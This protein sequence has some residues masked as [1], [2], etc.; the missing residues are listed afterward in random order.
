MSTDR[1]SAIAALREFL[2]AMRDWE[3]RYYRLY[4]AAL[5]DEGEAKRLGVEMCNAKR[6][7]IAQWCS[8]DVLARASFSPSV[9]DPPVFDPDRD[10]LIVQEAS[11]N[12]V[13]VEHTQRVGLESV[14]RFC[15]VAEH[16]CWVIDSVQIL[17]DDPPP[18]WV[19]MIL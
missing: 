7:I 12:K 14:H 11:E 4:R 15:M 16:G 8:P 3:L 13:V 6:E 19:P 1:V 10:G 18:N 2:S 5:S 9:G 17:E